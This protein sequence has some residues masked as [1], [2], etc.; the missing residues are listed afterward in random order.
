MSTS[1]PASTASTPVTTIVTLCTQLCGK[2]SGPCTCAKTLLVEAS[3]ASNINKTKRIYVA[4]DY[5]SNVTF[6][7][8]RNPSGE[9][10]MIERFLGDAF[11]VLSCQFWSIVL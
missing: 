7:H 6:I 10:F 5:Q 11:G 8:D 2:A 9:C 3:M 4:I 1:N